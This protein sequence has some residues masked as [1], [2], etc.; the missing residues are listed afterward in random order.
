M[1]L[2]RPD[3][4]AEA[5]PLAHY[6]QV[7][8]LN[9]SEL[10]PYIVGPH[11]PDRARPLSALAAEVADSANGFVDDISSALI[12]SCTNSSYQDM[13][14]A[15]DVSRQVLDHGVKAAIPFLVT[16]G[17]ERVRATIE[18]DGLIASIEAVGGTVLANACG[19]CI[20]QWRRPAGETRT[21][22]TIVTSFNRNFPRRNDGQATTMNFIASPE[23]V[24][25]L[26]MAGRLSF[27][28]MTDDLVAQDGQSFRLQ[29][30]APAPDVPEYGF[31]LR[32]TAYTAP[33][34]DG[35]IVEVAIAE[36]SNRLQ[37]LHPWAPWDGQDFLD[38]PI[39]VQTK[40]K[41]T[42]DDISPAGPWLALRGHLDK[43]SDNMFM[44]ARNSFTDA[45]GTTVNL[46]T[47]AA[48]RPIA[49]VARAYK[50]AGVK[51]VAIGDKNYG[52][53]S[54]REH[55]ALSPRLLG[56]AAIIARSFA[57]IHETNLKKQGLLP[58]TF[59]DAADYDL[60]READR[61]SLVDLA[62]LAPGR[63]V[64]CILRHSDGSEDVL[65]LRHSMTERQIGWF[66]AGSILNTIV[67]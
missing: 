62:N 59:S 34:E 8:E 6:D 28:P 12:G 10:E 22:N 17:S 61:L 64:K 23:I 48:Q 53:G 1:D 15:A 66:R 31:D 14:R 52:E 25:A 56:G 16:P 60:T 32:R 38:M 2:F 18:R 20:G 65:L 26:S 58:L 43:F 30:P 29:A 37:K 47:G 7:V 13:S 67:S 63:P 21:S 49:E 45:V 36:D 42:T 11:S 4:E 24:T 44:G 35:S 27:N 51:W 19:P 5:N 33:P 57:R 55:A 39:L 54:S 50:A 41:T 46:L 9:L 3:P 40:G